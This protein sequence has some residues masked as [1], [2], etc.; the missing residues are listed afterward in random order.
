M[1]LYPWSQW[2]QQAAWFDQ[3]TE[4]RNLHSVIEAQR[5]ELRI[6]QGVIDRLEIAHHG[7]SN[8]VVLRRF[9]LD[10]PALESSSTLDHEVTA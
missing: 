9:F 2:Y 3:V 5:T 6:A 8:A 10:L 4:V 7:A 1:A